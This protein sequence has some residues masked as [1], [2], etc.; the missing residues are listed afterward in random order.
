MSEVP[1]AALEAC[2]LTL[3][4]DGGDHIVVRDVSVRVESGEIVCLVGRSGCGKTTILHALSGLTSPLEGRVLLHGRDV[5]GHPG[6]V[7]YMLQ[8][9]LLIPSKRIIDNVCLPLVIRGAS[10][11]EARERV[12]PYFERFG[13]AGTERQWPSQLSGGMRQRAAFLRTYVMGNDVVLLDEPFSALDAITR[14]DLRSW[15]CDMARELGLASVV[16][17]HDVDEA[18]GMA[19][20]V[21]VLVGSP[22]TGVPTKVAGELTV[23]RTEGFELTEAYV[24]CK[25]EVLELLG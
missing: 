25:R 12:A 4:W 14:V 8:K 21:Y 2:G 3:S 19:D 6:K 17:T 20:R 5:T 24:A 18:V 23:P 7:S 16:I 11:A 10:K 22:R 1:D 13:L 9:D 15:Y